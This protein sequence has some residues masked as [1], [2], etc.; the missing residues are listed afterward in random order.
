MDVVGAQKHLMSRFT[1]SLA[2]PQDDAQ[3]RARMAQDWMAGDISI[4]FRREPNYFAGCQLQGDRVQVIACRDNSN[5]QI[6][7]LGSLCSSLM[8][9]NGIPTRA[10]YLADLRGDPAYRNGTLLARGYRYLRTLHEANPLPHYYSIIFD[11][12]EAALGALVHSRAGLPAYEPAGKIRTPALHLDFAKSPIL[13]EGVHLRRANQQ[14]L[15]A[16]VSF[17]NEHLA[18][19]QY[20]PVYTESDFLAGGRCSSLPINQFF[21]ALQD[22]RIIGTIAAWDQKDVR[23]THIEQ[24]CAKLKALRPLYNLASLVSPLKRLPAVGSRVPYLYL[25]CIAMQDNNASVFRAVLRFAYN[26]LRSGPWHYAIAGL[27]D[28]D[29][30]AAVLDEYRSIPTAGLLYRVNFDSNA[31]SATTQTK[32]D[33]RI[34]Y[35]EMAL[36]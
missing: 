1:F 15:G 16:I 19:K 3:L 2:T 30:L 11:T 18:L 33:N 25:C 4:S 23:Q 8:H 36:S 28:L 22:D 7:G 31:V 21:L 24:Y 20:S 35:V 13:V 17:L 12:N 29:P 5:N 34:P 26:E 9:I 32:P 6:V 10:G 27:H 14:D